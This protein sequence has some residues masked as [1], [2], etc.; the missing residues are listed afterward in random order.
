MPPGDCYQKQTP[1]PEFP[2]KKIEFADAWFDSC[3]KWFQIEPLWQ[4]LCS[5]GSG[6][7]IPNQE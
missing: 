2:L 1:K 4:S 6:K 3:S 5:I 7:N